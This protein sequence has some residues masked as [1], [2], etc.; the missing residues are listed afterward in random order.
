MKNENEQQNKLEELM[1]KDF[2]IEYE[3]QDEKEHVIQSMIQFSEIIIKLVQNK[4]NN[5]QLSQNEN[6]PAYKQA[7]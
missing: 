6:K 4:N 7:A 2:G 5:I 3:S 1:N